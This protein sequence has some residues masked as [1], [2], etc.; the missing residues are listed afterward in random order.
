MKYIKMTRISK[1]YRMRSPFKMA[2]AITILSGLIYSCGGQKDSNETASIFAKE[3][4][5]AWCIVPYDSE[6]RGPEE[7]AA[8]L[9]DLG[10]TK[11]AYDWRD[12]HIPSF[13]EELQ[14][15]EK[16]NIELQGFWLASGPDPA[17][18]KNLKLILEALERN[19]VQTQLWSMFGGW[20]GF[21]E[22]S[23]Q[24]KVETA[25]ETV[26]YVAKALDSIGSSLGLYNH[27]G[28]FGEPENQVAIIEH[29]KMDNIG[30]VY[31]FS[32]AET[33]AN[34]FEEFYP[35]IL[36]HL[37]AINI[38]GLKGGYPAEVVPVGQGNMEEDMM[39]LIQ[40]SSYDGPIGIINEDFAD[41]AKDGLEMNMAGIQEILKRWGDD[42]ALSTY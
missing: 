6:K 15:L 4:L 30:I 7:R 3:N 5:I 20:E 32:H 39:R 36:P 24:E 29:L 13:D 19:N 40:E 41:D 28:W 38:T 16:Q 33:Q 21:D 9:K 35:K 12:E 31:N 2:L 34:R 11:L 37:Y 25:A 42:E 17:N 1:L 27:G 22:L 18:D 26:A 8:M 14:T 10:I 23:Q